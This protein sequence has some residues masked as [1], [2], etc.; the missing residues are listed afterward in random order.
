M[1]L[2]GIEKELTIEQ[3]AGIISILVIIAKADKEVVDSEIEELDKVASY[4]D[5][6]VRHPLMQKIAIGRKAELMSILNTLTKTQ[7][8]WFITKMFLVIMAD[9]KAKD[10]EQSFF[11]GISKDLGFTEDE[12]IKIIEEKRMVEYFTKYLRK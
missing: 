9:G 8:K 7:K 5:F 3:K 6:D 2:V 10:I 11:E 1:E 12:V 4:L